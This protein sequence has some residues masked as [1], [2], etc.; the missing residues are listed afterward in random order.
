M[1]ELT[2][3]QQVLFET[4]NSQRWKEVDENLSLAEFREILTNEFHPAHLFVMGLLAAMD[5]YGQLKWK[6]CY[7]V[8]WS[9]I[10]EALGPL[11]LEE[12]SVLVGVLCP[13]F[14]P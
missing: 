8:T 4:M 13:P 2:T 1:Q 5:S 7:E 6:E 10:N 11:P 14:K 3:A 12:S 9:K